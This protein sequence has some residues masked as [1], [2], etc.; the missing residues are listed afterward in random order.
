MFGNGNSYR[1]TNR[2][3][4]EADTIIKTMPRIV[5]RIKTDIWTRGPTLTETD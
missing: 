2:I 4:T 1:T 3:G 5:I